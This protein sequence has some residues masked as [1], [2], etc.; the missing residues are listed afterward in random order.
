MT[1]FLL[2]R[3]GETDAVGKSI[4][5]WAPGW[6]LNRNGQRQVEALTARLAKAPIRAIYTSPLER[7]VE[8]AEAVAHPHGIEL[9]RDD[10]FGEFR[11]GDWEGREIA[12]LDERDDWR[13]FNSFRAGS[14]APNGELMLETQ[15]RMVR[16]LQA[17]VDGHPGETVAVVSHADPLRA[18]IAYYLGMPLDLMQRLEISP[19]SVSVLEV[20]DWHARFLCVNALSETLPS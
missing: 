11:M 5:G 7:A 15:T 19:A 12:K 16:R 10:A 17:L 2:I 18:L 8:T 13:R 4:M 9:R 1:I 6:H 3:H 20:S 14:R